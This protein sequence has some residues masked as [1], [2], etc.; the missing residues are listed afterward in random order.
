[1]YTLSKSLLLVA[2]AVAS[3]HTFAAAFDP[4]SPWMQG[5]WNGKRT[6]LQTQGYTFNVGYTGESATLLDS[7]R[8]AASKTEYAGQFAIG[9]GVDLEK[10]LGWDDTEA[11]ITLTWRDGHDLKNV[12]PGLSG[13]QSSVQEVWGRSQT[14][15]LTEFWIKKQF[16]DQKLDVKVGRFGESADFNP[17]ACDFQ[18][19]GLCGD[20]MGNWNAGDQI[21]NWPVSQWAARAKYNF[22]PEMF[23]Q[24]GVYEYNPENLKRGKGFNLSTDGSKGAVVPVELIWQPKSGLYGLPGEYRAG[25]YYSTDK[26]AEVKNPAKESNPQG[27]WL[28]FTQQLT[29]VADDADRG[30]KMIGQVAIFDTSTSAKRDMQSLALSYKGMSNYRPKDE[31][32]VGFSRI[33][34]NKDAYKNVDAEYNSEIYYGIH[35]NNWLTV[36]PNIQYVSHIGGIDR[37]SDDAWVGGVKFIAAF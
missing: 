12:S 36:R 7:S 17:A 18:N 8:D 21:H 34:L 26:V 20:Q 10:I 28:S 4:K 23:A 15:R 32:A 19:L 27:G 37:N 6:E 5:D 30:L 31:L 25:Y 29:Q 22:A 16:L 2:V 13:M 11:R 3:T 14:W 24:V 35:A 1:M 33:A 9:A